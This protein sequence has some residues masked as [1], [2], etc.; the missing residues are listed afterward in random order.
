MNRVQRE[1]VASGKTFNNTVFTFPLCC[2]SRATIQTGMYPHNTGVLAND[3]PKGGYKRFKANSLTQ[4]TVARWVDEAEYRTGY[5]GK[6]MNG[7]PSDAQI[8][9]WDEMKLRKFNRY[10]RASTLNQGDTRTGEAAMEFMAQEADEPFFV[11]ASFWAPHNPYYYPGRYK[12]L[13]QDVQVPRT[14]NMNEAD[15]SDKPRYVRTQKRR[16]MREIDAKYRGALRSLEP[17]DE[18]VGA[19][20][21]LLKARGE[22]D[23]TYVIFYTDNGTHTGYHRLSYGK[24]TPYEEDLVFPM[25]VR[26]P[27]IASGSST[28]LLIGNHDIAPTLA[29]LASA[30]VP[31]TVD[32][33]SLAPLLTDGHT[34]DSWRDVVLTQGGGGDVPRAGTGLGPCATATLSMRLENG[35]ST[36]W[37]R[38]PSR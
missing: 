25:A 7:T 28:N 36:T 31:S 19:S 1:V 34:P 16:D 4:N 21:E 38:I 24:H 35:N 37:R 3:W 6:Y 9:G 18:F 29:H 33:R 22:W 23:N 27:G 2:P 13:F 15:V 8:A 14:P 5:F 26:G 32:G 11:F 12:G 17:V 10:M 30:E 20:A